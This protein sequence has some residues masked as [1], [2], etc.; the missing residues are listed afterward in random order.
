M[1]IFGELN[2]PTRVIK[3]T[4]ID[5]STVKIMI[6]NQ[7]MTIKAE[8]IDSFILSVL[9]DVLTDNEFLDLE[10]RKIL[11]N[12]VADLEIEQVIGLRSILDTLLPDNLVGLDDVTYDNITSSFTFLYKDNT[13]KNIQLPFV[14]LEAGKALSSNDYTSTEKVKLA[15]I[16]STLIG[17]SADQIGRVD[18]IKV[19]GQSILINKIANI[20]L[21]G[22]I[23]NPQYNAETHTFSVNI[24]GSETPFI[25]DFPIESLISNIELDGENNLILYFEDDSTVSIPLN[26]LLVGVVKNIN[27]KTPNSNGEVVINIQDIEGLE[28]L[29]DTKLDK[30]TTISTETQL[31][32]KKIKWKPNNDRC[33]HISFSWVFAEWIWRYWPKAI[34]IKHLVEQDNTTITIPLR[35]WTTQVIVN[36]GDGSNNSS[37]S[38]GPYNITYAKKGIYT[39]KIY[40]AETESADFDFLQLT[41]IPILWKIISFINGQ[42]LYQEKYI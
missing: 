2:K 30:V 24:K 16:H 11:A 39:L 37:F 36:K 14:K 33:K 7:A 25:I 20:E 18:D 31:Y 10:T 1:T 15:G 3:Y 35:L 42:I 6:D 28:A 8:L 13:S 12:K 26:T 32:A 38:N 17:P 19:D 34:Y 5:T 23:Y 22:L 9:Q 29:I 41:I 4:P 27:N 40:Q 21:T